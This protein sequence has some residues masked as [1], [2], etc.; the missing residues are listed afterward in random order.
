M[1]LKSIKYIVYIIY[2]L[3]S[4]HYKCRNQNKADST[5][6]KNRDLVTLLV[7]NLTASAER[8]TLQSFFVWM[9]SFL[10]EM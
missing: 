7:K 1:L 9:V 6:H 5:V 10:V 8:F 3:L 4:F 2:K